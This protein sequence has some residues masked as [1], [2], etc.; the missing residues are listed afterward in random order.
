MS[1]WP[2]LLVIGGL[3]VIVGLGVHG[4]TAYATIAR[5]NLSSK[6]ETPN[7]LVL[8]QDVATNGPRVG[9]TVETTS[10]AAYGKS[11]EQYVLDGTGVTLGFVLVVGGLF[12]SVNSR[13]PAAA[14]RGELAARQR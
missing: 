11:L 2:S 7:P 12:V 13:E 1:R 14:E 6:I 10:R 9:G 5:I 3:F 4:Y 8:F